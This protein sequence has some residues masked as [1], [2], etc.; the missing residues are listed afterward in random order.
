MGE[1]EIIAYV[2]FIPLHFNNFNIYINQRNLHSFVFTNRFN[3][4]KL[5][6]V[7]SKTEFRNVVFQDI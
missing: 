7:K 4:Q 6:L 5:F 2:L 3:V 1:R